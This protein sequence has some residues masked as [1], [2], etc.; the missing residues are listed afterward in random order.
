[1]LKPNLNETIYHPFES[2]LYKTCWLK[3]LAQKFAMQANYDYFGY[4]TKPILS[5]PK[6]LTRYL[7]KL[8]KIELLGHNGPFANSFC[9][10]R[11]STFKELIKTE[12]WDAFELKGYVSRPSGY[13]LK[14]LYQIFTELGLSPLVM[15]DEPEY[16]IQME[17]GGFEAYLAKKSKKNRQSIRRRFKKVEHLSPEFQVYQSADEI[18]AFFNCFFRYH[19][20]YWKTDTTESYFSDSQERA[21]ILD[22]STGLS[23]QGGLH[24]HRFKLNDTLVNM[25]MA[26]HNTSSEESSK[27]I[28]YGHLTINTGEYLDYAPGILSTFYELQYAFEQGFR[29]FN[30]GYG[31]N[32]FKANAATHKLNRYKLLLVNPK[33]LVGHAYLM[34]MKKK[35]SSALLNHETIQNA[36]GISEL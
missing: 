17:D 16:L 23:K 7:P 5:K 31:L 35:H 4:F 13:S 20:T 24:L 29:W 27:D 1:M 6:V 33:S 11:L 32:P 9:E 18:N 36:E 26:M 19:E 22:F 14:A 28:F 12:K 21:F 10:N 15:T 34:Q 30:L 25:G 3:H 2:L 8:K